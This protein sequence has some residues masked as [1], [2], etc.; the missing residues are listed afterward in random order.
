LVLLAAANYYRTD[1]RVVSSL[2]REVLISPDRP[3]VNTS[4]LVLGHIH[5]EHYVSLHHVHTKQAHISKN[6]WYLGLK[7]LEKVKEGS[8][9]FEELED[10]A[11][12]IAEAWKR[13][14]RR[15]KFDES[16][17][18]GFHKENEEYSEK[19]YKMLLAWKQRNASA[20][21]YRVLHDALCHNLVS[22]R[23]LA[24]KFCCH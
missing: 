23:D 12:C 24:E 5:E 9:S 7:C 22:R 17:L 4:P 1:I 11:G 16:Q 2:G 6:I 3:V 8:P 20:A 21:T 15:L 19:A 13:L 10:L 18:T 14:G